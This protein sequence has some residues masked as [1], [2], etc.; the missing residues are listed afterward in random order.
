M[1]AAVLE[2]ALDTDDEMR[3]RMDRRESANG[4]GVEYAEYVELSFLRK[5]RTIGKNSERDVH[6]RKVE[7]GP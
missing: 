2:R 7:E 6:R 1:R 4:K 5:V 3:P